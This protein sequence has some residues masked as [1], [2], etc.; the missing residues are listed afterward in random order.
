LAVA[1]ACAKDC[2]DP[3]V[4]EHSYLSISMD[5]GNP[6]LCASP[7]PFPGYPNSTEV[8]RAPC[9]SETLAPMFWLAAWSNANSVPMQ[10]LPACAAFVNASQ[11]MC[12][13]EDVQALQTQLQPYKHM[14][15]GCEPVVLVRRGQCTFVQKVN[16]TVNAL[17]SMFPAVAVPTVLLVDDDECNP[18]LSMGVEGL[19]GI[20]VRPAFCP[21]VVGQ[22]LLSD[23]DG[24]GHSAGG[25]SGVKMQ[26]SRSD[27]AARWDRTHVMPGA[28]LAPGITCEFQMDGSLVLLLCLAAGALVVGSHGSGSRMLERLSAANQLP[29]TQGSGPPP[30]PQEEDAQVVITA[31]MAAVYG[32]MASVGLVLMFLFLD[33]IVMVMVVYVVVV[34]SCVSW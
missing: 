10:P 18:Y 17:S 23:Y 27:D 31:K 25:A 13:D 22:K 12:A 2:P 16:H 1:C 21:L 19:A 28:C 7:E 8:T 32:L 34:S 24:D 20:S 30:A 6:V 5:G 11:D 15:A 29:T 3:P 9:N 14:R 4:V 33:K 26:T